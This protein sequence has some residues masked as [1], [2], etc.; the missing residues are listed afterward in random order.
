MLTLV[1]CT[2]IILFQYLYFISFGLYKQNTI[3][4]GIFFIICIGFYYLMQYFFFSTFLEYFW[5]FFYKQNTY[6]NLSYSYIC[7]FYYEPQLKNYFLL[8]LKIMMVLSIVLLFPIIIFG[9]F[10][11]QVQSIT[12]IIKGRKYFYLFNIFMINIICPPDLFL[13]LFLML[14]ILS[15]L[16]FFL[17]IL[18]IF[19]N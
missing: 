4:L 12:Q 2:P 16:E 10:F 3:R 9:L 15:F 1:Y 17:F 14:G 11:F 18:Y 19:K 7:K 6:A 13:Q 8:I 5:C